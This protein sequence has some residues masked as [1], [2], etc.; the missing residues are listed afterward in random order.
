MSAMATSIRTAKGTSSR[1]EVAAGEN[2]PRKTQPRLDSLTSLRFFAASMILLL[3]L[4]QLF[5]FNNYSCLQ[6]LALWQGV[7]FFFVLSGFILAYVHPRIDTAT[8]SNNFL[9]ARFARIWPTHFAAFLFTIALVPAVLNVPNLVPVAVANL[10]MVQVWAF[11]P[12]ISESFNSVSWTISIELF[13]YL[14]FPFLLKDFDRAVKIRWIGAVALSLS[15]IALCMAPSLSGFAPG[16]LPTALYLGENPICR[17]FEFTLGI[18]V[19][20]LFKRKSQLHSLSS[21]QATILEIAALTTIAAA[22]NLSNLWPAQNATGALSVLRA[23]AIDMGGAPA[24]AALIL[25]VASEKGKIAQFLNKKLLVRLGEISFSMYMF[26]LSILY[27]LVKYQSSFANLPGWILPTIGVSLC[28]IVS[29]LNYTFIETPFRRRITNFAKKSASTSTSKS[30][31]GAEVRAKPNGLLAKNAPQFLD[32][33]TFTPPFPDRNIWTQRREAIIATTG[34]RF[35]SNNKAVVLAELA[36]LLCLGVWLNVQF[37][38]VP[39][40][41]AQRIESHSIPNATGIAFGDKFKLRGLK[42]SKKADGL[43]LDVIWQSLGN[44]KLDN[45]NAVD[46]IDPKCKTL[47]SQTYPQDSFNRNVTSG[48]IWQDKVF[49]P[50]ADLKGGLRLGLSV[51]TAKTG[52]ALRTSGG[53]SDGGGSRLLVAIP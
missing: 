35:F 44:Q 49:I 24:Y 8:Q 26:H 19:C 1:A 3:H 39:A 4:S 33:L 45:L 36:I 42:V 2:L 14:C 46:I 13:F 48:K 41:I 12:A 28:L 20:W 7:S 21:T 10:C 29:H 40:M 6:G 53:F 34:N 16:T 23:W 27:A 5:G 25:L 50:T 47:S 17:L 31:D 22:I 11:N 43:Y 37:R 38:F 9:L 15:F 51:H 18:F 52:I 32:A 30:I